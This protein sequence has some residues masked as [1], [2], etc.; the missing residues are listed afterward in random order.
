MVGNITAASYSGGQGFEILPAVRT[1]PELLSSSVNQTGLPWT[2][3]KRFENPSFA[4][5]RIAAICNTGYRGCICNSSSFQKWP[6][7]THIHNTHAHT[8]KKFHT[9]ILVCPQTLSLRGTAQQHAVFYLWEQLKKTLVYSAPKGNRHFGNACQ[10]IHSGRG[11][12]EMARQSTIRRWRTFSAFSVNCDLI[13]I[14]NSTV[15][16]LGKCIVNVLS[17]VSRILHI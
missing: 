12:F 6:P 10:I 8:K 4:L 1:T 7:Y 2:N 11:T 13:N 14:K 9:N 15:I 17:V 5:T 3:N 16:K